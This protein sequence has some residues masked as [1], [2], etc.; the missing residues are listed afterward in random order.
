MALGIHNVMAKPGGVGMG[1]IKAPRVGRTSIK[2]IGIG[3]RGGLGA[4][5]NPGGFNRSALG[6]RGRSAGP[7]GLGGRGK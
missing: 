6:A 3:S 4:I 5:K 1:R 2:G 7:G